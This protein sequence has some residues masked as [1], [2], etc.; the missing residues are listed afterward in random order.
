VVSLSLPSLTNNQVVAV[1]LTESD[2]AGSG[3]AG[4]FLSSS[5]TEPSI[6]D[7]GWTSAKP[8]TFTLPA[9]DGSKTVYA[10]VKNNAG[11]VSLPDSAATVLDTTVP[12]VFLPSFAFVSPQTVGTTVLV[13]VS[14]PA[15]T[16]ASGISAY[17][18]QIKRN[19]SIW[20][21]VALPQLTA[22]SVDMAL[23]PGDVYRF[24]LSAT[25]GADN[26]SADLTTAK[27]KLKLAQEKATAVSYAGKWKRVSL[28][29]ASGGYVKRSTTAGN[30]A[31]F[32]FSGRYVGFV[33]TLGPARGIAEIRVDGVLL[34]TIDMYSAGLQTKRVMWSGPVGAG[35]HIIE[36]RVTGT[37][38]AASTS[39]RI[40]VDGFLV[41]T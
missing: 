38:N 33:T 27:S 9:G 41:W 6:G 29:G 34:A 14:W 20:T 4:W 21:T 3:I 17:W 24:R 12:T 30:R 1:T 23:R 11:T 26:T 32:S 37:R 15:A 8:T 5:A 36:V 39:T 16:D 19:T 10:W 25:D 31:S 40:D 22:T 2:P 13:R 28:T 7:P 18:L 35:T